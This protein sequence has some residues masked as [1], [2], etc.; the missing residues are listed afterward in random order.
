MD[1]DSKRKGKPKEKPGLFEWLMS[2]RP[3][4]ARHRAYERRVKLA[5]QA[6]RIRDKCGH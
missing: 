1:D 5:Q 3:N 6:W 2:V 4:P